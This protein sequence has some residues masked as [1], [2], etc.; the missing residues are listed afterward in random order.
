[1]TNDKAATPATDDEVRQISW[2]LRGKP[3]DGYDLPNI[4]V[5]SLIARIE[6]LQAE[7]TRLRGLCGEAAN[8]WSGECRR[9]G[10]PILAEQHRYNPPNRITGMIAKLDRAS[11]GDV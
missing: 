1:M 5:F 6:V 7:V 4:Y 9:L 8:L 3:E 11:K 2:N 10:T